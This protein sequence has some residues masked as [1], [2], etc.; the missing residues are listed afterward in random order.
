[1]P[2]FLSSG[3]ALIPVHGVPGHLVQAYV[4]GKGDVTVDFAPYANASEDGE[5]VVLDEEGDGCFIVPQVDFNYERI[6]FVNVTV[7]E[8][9]T[10]QEE[11]ATLWVEIL[12]IDS[13]NRFTMGELGRQVSEWKVAAEEAVLKNKEIEELKTALLQEN[14]RL[15]AEKPDLSKIAKDVEAVNFWSQDVITSISSWSRVTSNI[16]ESLARLVSSTSATSANKNTPVSPPRS[17][18][19]TAPR[20]PTIATPAIKKDLP[21]QSPAKTAMAPKSIKAP[22]TPTRGIGEESSI[23]A[24][25]VPVTDSMLA[26]LDGIRTPPPFVSE[27]NSA[28]ASKHADI[29]PLKVAKLT[30][31]ALAKPSGKT[32]PEGVP[33]TI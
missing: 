3:L 7:M 6:Y 19:K 24:E 1:M 14:A 17:A 33:S 20:N 21:T 26:E 9:E 10:L 31:P 27:E 28:P 29:K 12:D 4:K 13:C 2:K 30:P 32:A 11:L 22:L 18:A 25:E 15:K 23:E 8:I 5:S 16:Q